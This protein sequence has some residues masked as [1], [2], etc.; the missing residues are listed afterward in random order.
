MSIYQEEITFLR[1]HAFSKRAE[2][3]ASKYMEQKQN[4]KEV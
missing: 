3:F 2:G 4:C 1:A